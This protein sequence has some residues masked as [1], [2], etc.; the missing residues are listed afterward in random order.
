VSVVFTAHVTRVVAVVFVDNLIFWL[1]VSV[2]V[3]RTPPIRFT[4]AAIVIA[5]LFEADF[6]VR[7]GLGAVCAA[8]TGLVT[9]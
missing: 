3:V 8:I 2:G 5:D 6:V 9:A 4:F 7:G 1:I